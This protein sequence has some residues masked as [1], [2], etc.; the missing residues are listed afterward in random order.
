MLTVSGS[1]R[2]NLGDGD[3][4]DDEG[5]VE[6]IIQEEPVSLSHAS[7]TIIEVCLYSTVSRTYIDTLVDKNLYRSLVQQH[8]S[9]F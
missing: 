6:S 8:T 3:E 4:S 7:V 5:E 1:R 9:C 2:F